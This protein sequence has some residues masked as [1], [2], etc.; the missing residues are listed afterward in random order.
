MVLSAPSIYL[1][2]N[3]GGTMIMGEMLGFSPSPNYFVLRGRP[4]KVYPVSR[5]Q[6]FIQDFRAGLVEVVRIHA[7]VPL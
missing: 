5:L 6:S 1:A 4:V 2:L 7:L 3:R